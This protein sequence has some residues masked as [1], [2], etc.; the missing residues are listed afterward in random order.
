M[1]IVIA[2]DKF[3]GSLTS[4]E[5]ADAISE[6]IRT[7]FP[8]CKIA[9]VSVAD[10]GDGTA[11]I[12]TDSLQGIVRETETFDALRRLVTSNYGIVNNDTA[13]IDIASASG[14]AMLKPE[15]RNPMSTSTF[16]TGLLIRDA[17]DLGM[18][19]FLIGV[20]G[21]ATNDG[22]IGLLSALG[23][24]FRNQEGCPLPPSGKS[25]NEICE[26]DDS[27]VIPEL[28][29]CQFDILCDVDARFYG[30][31]GAAYVFAPQKGAS[32]DE[33]ITLDNG[34]RNFAKIIRQYNGK[35][36]QDVPYA[37][38]AGAAGGGMWA[39][40]NAR[41][42]PGIETMLTTIGFE[43]ILEGADLVITGEGA[44]DQQTFMGK[45]PY[46]VAMAANAKNIPTILLAGSVNAFGNQDDNPFAGVYSIQPRP[47]DLQTALQKGFA[48]DNLRHTAE[49]IFRTLKAV[50]IY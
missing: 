48:Y 41:L 50:G 42:R 23:F 5:V 1:K 10:G 18:R 13:V 14:L 6:G 29:E 7:V 17:I 16:G 2:S 21:S 44:V 40:I 22:G 11:Q 31:Q 8:S 25:L 12:I 49:Q 20:G 38:A 27:A 30:P 37:G 32:P 33:V 47:V 28:W 35:N 46:G 34:L 26:I 24:I 43:K 15:E 9:K 45:T 3:K 39:L 4:S 19:K 36:V